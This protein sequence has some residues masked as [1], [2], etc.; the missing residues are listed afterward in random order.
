M[1]CGTLSQ[2]RVN[3]IE[4]FPGGPAV[5]NPPANAG[6][7]GSILV[8]EDPTCHG[9]TKLI[10]HNY[11]SLCSR[12]QELQQLKDHTPESLCSATRE[13]TTMGNPGIATEE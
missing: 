1:S 3:Y 8:W 5:K 11:G 9:T 13:A 6:N 7:T 2:L 12:A 4:G 10:N